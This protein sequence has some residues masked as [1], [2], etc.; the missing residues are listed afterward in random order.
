MIFLVE[1]DQI[2]LSLIYE[3]GYPGV[4]SCESG[5]SAEYGIGDGGMMD[6]DGGLG[7]V[8]TFDFDNRGGNIAGVN[9]LQEERCLK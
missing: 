3:E 4:I 6:G 7:W 9:V 5:P 1:D 2:I 8:I